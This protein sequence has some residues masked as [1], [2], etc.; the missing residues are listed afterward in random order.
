MPRAFL[1]V[2]TQIDFVF[3][4]GALYASGAEQVIAVVVKLNRFATENKIPLVSTMCAHGEDDLEFTNWGPHCV[5][6]TLG[7]RK[8]AAL[9]MGQPIFEKQDTDLFQSPEAE[10][11]LTEIG[12]DEWIVYGVF[13][14]VCVEQAALGLLARGKR[15]IVVEDAVKEIDADAA[16]SFWA[17]LKEFGGRVMKSEDILAG[18]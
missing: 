18:K 17:E 13:T 2:D 16:A 10:P 3:P 1:D 15:V 5:A 9:L 6:G 12:A 7:Q 8:P 4:S 11:M 14:E